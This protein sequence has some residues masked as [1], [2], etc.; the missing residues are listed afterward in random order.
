[1]KWQPPSFATNA[2]LFKT[3]VDAPKIPVFSSVSLFNTVKPST[4]L[5]SQKNNKLDED[6]ED[7]E[8]LN[9]S[10]G[11]DGEEAPEESKEAANTSPDA[12]A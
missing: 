1:L 12:K 10:D 9:S 3:G 8:E 2:N 6:S 5:S 7:K 4:D 11:G